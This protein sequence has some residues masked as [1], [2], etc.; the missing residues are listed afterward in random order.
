M[1]TIPLRPIRPTTLLRPA[2]CAGLLLVALAAWGCTGADGLL[3]PADRTLTGDWVAVQ[4]PAD[5]FFP[6]ADTFRISL[7]QAD[8]SWAGTWG[9]VGEHGTVVNPDQP[10]GGHI[11]GD[12]VEI[13]LIYSRYDHG[14]VGSSSECSPLWYRALGVFAGPDELHVRVVGPPHP[15]IPDSELHAHTEWV[16]RRE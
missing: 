11:R 10:A 6:D 5:S 3:P 1:P 7:V 2:A 13:G 9:A 8:T 12:S 4:D 16:L 14:C 15:T